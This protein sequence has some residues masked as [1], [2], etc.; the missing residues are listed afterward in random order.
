MKMIAI[1]DHVVVQ[2]MK[3]EERLSKGGLVIPQTAIEEPQKF[4]KVLSVGEKVT[5]VRE[6]DIVV[7]AKF[8]GQAF[9]V[10]NEYLI[11]LKEPEIYCI[12]RD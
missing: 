10:D 9:V 6:G 1:N 4:G 8:G 12:L 3:K 11:V 7:F 5:S 2:E